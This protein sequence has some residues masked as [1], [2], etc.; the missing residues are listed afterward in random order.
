MA[1]WIPLST[2]FLFLAVM[3]KSGVAELRSADPTLEVTDEWSDIAMGVDGLSST[4]S[5]NPI[6]HESSSKDGQA[7]LTELMEIMKAHAIPVGKCPTFG[8]II[9]PLFQLGVYQPFKEPEAIAMQKNLSGDANF[10][11]PADFGYFPGYGYSSQTQT[12]TIAG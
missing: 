5:D 10:E 11:L 9:T 3:W 6:R 7:E 1:H 2:S 4:C 12:R 8:D